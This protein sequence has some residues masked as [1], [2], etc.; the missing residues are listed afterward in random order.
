[1]FK[2]NF[3]KCLLIFFT[4]LIL[5]STTCIATDTQITNSDLYLEDETYYNVNNVVSGNVFT[6]TDTFILG[7]DTESAIIEGNLFAIASTVKLTSVVTYSE[8]LEHDGEPVLENTVSASSILGNAY[9]IA[10]TFI[11]ERGCKIEGDLYVIASNVEI[12]SDVTV[13]G[14]IFIAGENVTSNARVAGG[15]YVASETFN[16]NYYGSVARDANIFAD[17]INLN[18][19]F[20]RNVSIEA[21]DFSSNSDFL[22]YENA[23]ITASNIKFTGEVKKN[24][25]FKA[26]NI[27]FNIENKCTILGNLN[28][29]CE[30]ELNLSEDIVKGQT[31]YTKYVEENTFLKDLIDCALSVI[32]FII[33]VFGIVLSYKFIF[34]K[35]LNNTNSNITVKNTF[36]SFGIGLASA[37]CT[38][39]IPI[40]LF[41]TGVGSLL[42]FTLIFA[43]LFVLFISQPIFIIQIAQKIKLNT[44]IYVKILLVAFITS[45]VSLIPFVGPVCYTI[46]M[47]TSVGKVLINCF[48]K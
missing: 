25:D 2:I 22:V 43:Y 26:K 34:K 11:V 5:L 16:M 32:A 9:I 8:D 7:S 1:M 45:V 35:D 4:L 40:F 31:K 20:R 30:E 38:I 24:A 17:R 48:S 42:G 44:N 13:S 19:V 27:E 36:A 46:F 33:Y 15:L 10:D 12:A 37:F 28:Y 14:N 23:K 29:S 3:K 21:T 47:F 6:T 41:I 18:G 39:V